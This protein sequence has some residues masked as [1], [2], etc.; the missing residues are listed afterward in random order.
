VRLTLEY[1]KKEGIF[2][3]EHISSDSKN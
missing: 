2:F 3:N 1:I